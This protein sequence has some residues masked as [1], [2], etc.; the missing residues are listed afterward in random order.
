MDSFT[1]IA[2]GAAVAHVTL[3]KRFGKH[4]LWIGALWGTIPDLDVY[5]AP[6]LFPNDPLAE[7]QFHRGFSHSVPF[8]LLL[9][10]VSAFI[11][12]KLYKQEAL[13]FLQW[14]WS[15]FLIL[16]TH[17]LLDIFTTWGTQLL[18]P[19]PFKFDL[20]SI[21]VV[22]PLYTLPLVIGLVFYYT[23][24]H[25]KWIHFG[26][27]LSSLYLLI[28]LGIQYF[29]TQKIKNEAQLKTVEIKRITV[30]PT[31]FNSILW[32]VIIETPHS[33]LLNQYSLNDSKV[34]QLK[35]FDKNEHLFQELPLSLQTQFMEITQGQYIMQKN[36][37]E[38]VL[39]DLRFGLLKDTD[40]EQ[41]FAFSYKIY[42]KNEKWIVEEVE[43][44]RR[45]GKVMLEKMIERIKGI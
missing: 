21:F 25:I 30:K 43:K 9:S 2:L 18:W 41:Q 3:P 19:L 22:D 31:A 16:L 8:F 13:S 24:N 28:G 5:I 39:N 4:R 45:D 44:D 34:E 10:G 15:I 32:N 11:L 1:Q 40:K 37:N 36:N 7:V 27:V 12:K 17:S 42:R 35:A 38:Y 29:I 23:K 6:L 20:H 26:F 14:Y 33:F